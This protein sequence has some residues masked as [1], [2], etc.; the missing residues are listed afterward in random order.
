MITEVRELCDKAVNILQK[1]IK[2][3]NARRKP[4]DRTVW[5]PL[6]E[7][8]EAMVDEAVRSFRILLAEIVFTTIMR[9]LDEELEHRSLYD[10]KAK[11]CPQVTFTPLA[12][13]LKTLAQMT[14]YLKHEIDVMNILCT[15]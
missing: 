10:D 7:P 8:L 11:F 14:R 6:V 12:H 2:P 3:A 9:L 15:F 5:F 13:S 4:M 1:S